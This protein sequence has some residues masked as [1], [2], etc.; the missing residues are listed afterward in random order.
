MEQTTTLTQAEALQIAFQAVRLYSEMHPRPLHI[1]QEQAAEM[2]GISGPTLRKMIH[3][4]K[5]KLNACGKI[6]ISE[7]DRAIAS[8]QEI[9][10]RRE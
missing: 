4:G 3:H 8:R 5:V 6:P 1:N 2:L 9:P 10:R 7:V